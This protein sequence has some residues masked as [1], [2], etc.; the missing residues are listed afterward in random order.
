V[1]VKALQIS[2]HGLPVEVVELV[3]IPEPDSP[4]ANEVL[5]AV[6]YAPINQSEAGSSEALTDLT[7]FDE[8]RRVHEQA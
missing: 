3:D 5:V 6:E 4:K 1:D 8:R 7:A 2:K